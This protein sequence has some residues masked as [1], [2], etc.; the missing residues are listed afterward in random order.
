VINRE[1]ERESAGDI[2]TPTTHQYC[3]GSVSIVGVECTMCVNKSC[4]NNISNDHLTNLQL[5]DSS[6]TI[7]T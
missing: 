2:H 3:N 6:D 7:H 1:R 5:H 4:E